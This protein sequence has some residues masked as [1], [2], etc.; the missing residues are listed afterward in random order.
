MRNIDIQSKINK[1]KTQLDKARRIYKEKLT[2][3]EKILLTH[4]NDIIDNN[5]E[6]PRRGESYINLHPDRVIMQDATAQMSVLQF[7]NS[8]YKNTLLP[9]SIHCDHLIVAEND[10][11]SD[12]DNAEKKNNEIYDFL[13][14]AAQKYGME[15]WGPGSGIIHQVVL[16]NYA[17][18]GCLIIGT[19]SHTPN[20]GGLGAL[21][22]GVGGTDAVDV[23][24]G[25]PFILKFP[26]VIGVNLTGKLNSWSSSKDVILHLMKILTVKG[27]TGHVVEFLGEGCNSLSTTEKATITNMGADRKSTRLNPVT[28]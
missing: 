2:L 22:I 8:G 27:G 24:M 20:A 19:D 7:I 12:L 9:T 23:M 25:E 14:T 13:N 3:T 21:A 17:F 16:E 18:P 26:K 6:I 5:G 15:F 10:Y 11:R 1:F 28:Q 4:M